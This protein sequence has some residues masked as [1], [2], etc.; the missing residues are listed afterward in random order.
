MLP[1]FHMRKHRK[2]NHAQF[3]E[4]AITVIR[5]VQ[6]VVAKKI[7][8]NPIRAFT[9]LEVKGRNNKKLLGVDYAAESEAADM[10]REKIP[11]L[12][13]LGEESLTD[14]SLDLTEEKSLVVLMD[15]VDGTDL[16]ER[17]LSN[18][19]SA[20][21]FFYPAERRILGSFVGIFGHGVYFATDHLSPRFQPYSSKGTAPREVSSPAK[22][23]DARFQWATK[24]E[25]AS[26]AY[27]GQKKMNYLSLASDSRFTARISALPEGAETRIYNLA[28]NP[29]MM[30]VIDGH[31][32]IDA[33]FDV[34]GQHPHDVAP[35]AFIASK[36][37]GVVFTDMSGGEIDL[38]TSL[39]R[40]ASDEHKLKYVLAGTESLAAEIR[41]AVS[42]GPDKS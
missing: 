26:V 14:K 10:L 19:C 39:L 37:P 33:V 28:G 22:D 2:L 23:V 15:M 30:R 9:P 42:P 32:R 16:L 40:P 5:E 41:A 38:T 36:V 13:T 17:G 3:V 25:D 31:K 4:T 6:R 21:V 1:V 29:M 24:L 35:G 20:M 27:Y 8:L 34:Q 18:W 12:V 11:D 7:R